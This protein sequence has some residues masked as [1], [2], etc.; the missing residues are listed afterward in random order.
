[1]KTTVKIFLMFFVS[2]NLMLTVGC[3]S[4]ATDGLNV[5]DPGSGNGGGVIPGTADGV[6]GD[7]YFYVGVDKT[8]NNIAHVHASTGFSDPCSIINTTTTSTDMECIIEVPEASTYYSGLALKVNQP[9]DM[10]RALVY[11]PYWYYNEEIGIGPTYVEVTRS[12]VVNASGDVTWGASIDCDIGDDGNAPVA[13]AGCAGHTE[14]VAAI[15]NSNGTVAVNCRYNRANEDDKH[16]CCL[17]EYT[18]VLSTAESN[19]ATLFNGT[20]SD[21]PTTVKWGGDPQNCIGGPG[22]GWPLVDADNFPVGLYSDNPNPDQPHKRDFKILETQEVIPLTAGRAWEVGRYSSNFFTPAVHTHSG[23]VS[24]STSSNPYYVT[25][26]DDRSG[27]PVIS[28]NASYMFECLDPSSEMKH[29]ISVKV[30]EWDSYIDYLLYISS[31][32]T[33]GS[34]DR[35]GV[36]ETPGDANCDGVSGPCNDFHDADDFVL[37]AEELNAAAYD[38]TTPANRH[39]NFPYDVYK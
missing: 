9:A 38:T 28:G 3:N 11:R 35:R 32:G 30:R 10:C 26:I 2:A 39:Q 14:L 13:A 8:V 22:K 29:R 31:T 1:M 12:K 23:Y 5:P 24:A 36:A 25:P 21:L 7:N 19:D 15:D 18:Y 27:S 33:S 34:P 6:A 16:N 37:D 4:G 17:G 20:T